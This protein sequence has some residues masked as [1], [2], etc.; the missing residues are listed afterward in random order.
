MPTTTAPS[1][2]RQTMH[3]RAPHLV[4]VFKR[5][6]EVTRDL[7][8]ALLAVETAVLARVPVRRRP[9]ARA[10]PSLSMPVA[11]QEAAAMPVPA[12]TGPC[13]PRRP[14]FDAASVQAVLAAA[15]T[16]TGES[17]E[18]LFDRRWSTRR[19]CSARYVAAVVLRR[20][21]MSMTEIARV[22]GLADHSTVHHGLRTVD[23]SAEL[24]AQADWI[25]QRVEAVSA[26]AE[27]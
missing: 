22:V 8:A 20:M 21:G 15:A 24:R 16:L 25:G 17:V 7:E 12:T 19:R 6:F 13:T 27:A 11:V 9:V 14:K 1:P 5:E 18:R 3:T 4:D 23:A 26:G 2:R 10:A